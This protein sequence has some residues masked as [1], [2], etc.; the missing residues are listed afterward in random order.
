MAQNDLTRFRKAQ[1]MD[2]AAAL[3]EIRGGRKESHW[4]WY[5]FPQLRG[6]GRSET[7]YYYGLAD[8]EEAR[9]FLDDPVL[10]HNLRE[11]TE[12]LL[13]LEP[14]DPLR[15]FGSPDHLKLHSCMTLFSQVSEAGSVFHRVLDRYFG[16]RPDPGTLR[17]LNK[18]N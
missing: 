11:I 10:G 16:G 9:A 18:Q 4:M 7:S 8:L 6:L 1:E 14:A 17:L 3:R 12:A 15:V 13:A 2:Y 5:I